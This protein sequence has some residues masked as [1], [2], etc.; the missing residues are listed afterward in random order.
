[1]LQKCYQV[2]FINREISKA[3]QLLKEG[4]GFACFINFLGIEYFMDTRGHQTV[5]PSGS[6]LPMPQERALIQQ[7]S[8]TDIPPLG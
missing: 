3:N 1:V 5:S 4:D 7:R 6:E 2:V 8:I